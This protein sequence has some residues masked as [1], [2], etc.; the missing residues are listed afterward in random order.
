MPLKILHRAITEL[1]M[2]QPAEVLIIAQTTATILDIR[3]LHRHRVAVPGVTHSL[4]LQTRGDVFINIRLH[5]FRVHRLFHLFKQCLIA[6]H[7]ARLDQRRLGLHILVGLPH[8][9]P[10]SS[11]GMADLQAHIPKR[12]EHGIR[13][14]L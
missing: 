13:Y 14:T 12:V 3:F 5:A 10:H 4:I 2:H 9:I 8:A 11:H 6:R 7:T 1:E